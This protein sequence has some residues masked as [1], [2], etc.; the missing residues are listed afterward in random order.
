ML[1]PV[2]QH[3]AYCSVKISGEDLSRYSV[4]IESVV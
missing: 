1:W 4:K 2:G 3:S